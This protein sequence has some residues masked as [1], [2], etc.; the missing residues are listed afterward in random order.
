LPFVGGMISGSRAAYEYLPDSI[1]QF[2]SAPELRSM[3]VAAGFG[4]TQY[5]LL[6]GGIAALHVGVKSD[7]GARAA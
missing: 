6:T 3:M 4:S 7:S 5:Q 2:P 1:R